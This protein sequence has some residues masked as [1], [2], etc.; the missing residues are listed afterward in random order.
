[1]DFLYSLNF[2][3]LK[4]LLMH[5]LKKRLNS[6]WNSKKYDRAS[7]FG[8]PILKVRQSALSASIYYFWSFYRIISHAKIS[9]LT[10]LI[11]SQFGRT[12][13]YITRKFWYYQ[14]KI[15]SFAN[16]EFTKNY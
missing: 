15:N 1:M 10:I 3:N 12:K 4:T 16:L 5:Q 11:Q 6:V 14:P 7:F 9:I 8:R 13:K 2:K